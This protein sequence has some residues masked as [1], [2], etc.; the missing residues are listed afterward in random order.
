M[1]KHLA[2]ASLLATVLAGGVIVGLGASMA[3]L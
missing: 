3:F 2:L 1:S